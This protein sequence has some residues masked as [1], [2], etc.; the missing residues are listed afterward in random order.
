MKKIVVIGAGSGFYPDGPMVGD[1]IFPGQS[2]S[3]VALGGL[4]V[5]EAVLG[6]RAQTLFS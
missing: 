4:R 2:T 3:A 6:E 5:A 1:S